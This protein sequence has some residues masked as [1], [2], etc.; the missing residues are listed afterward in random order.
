M[1][2][3]QFI[4]IVIMFVAASILIAV[5][6]FG[7]NVVDPEYSSP[8]EPVLGGNTIKPAETEAPT[9][10]SEGTD[11]PNGTSDPSDATDGPTAEPTKD[12]EAP[13][14]FPSIHNANFIG[15]DNSFTYWSSY[16]KDSGNGQ[17][18]PVFDEN[19][20]KNIGDVEY[21]FIKNDSADEWEVYLTFAMH[22]D[23]GETAKILDALKSANAKATFFVTAM[24]IQDNPELVKRM[25]D[26]GH[27]I[28]TRGPIGEDTE[29][30]S[31]EEF[32]AAMLEVEKE[33]Q[34]LFG[35]KERMTVYRPDYFSAR[36][37]KVAE[38]LEY[39]IVFRTYTAV[40]DEAGWDKNKTDSAEIAL[41]LWERGAYEGSV[42]EFT[43]SKHI[44]GA[45]AAYLKECNEN[46][47]TFKRLDQ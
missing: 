27:L 28:G 32:A 21:V 38:A 16:W 15:I 35:E 3:S 26:E 18:V 10:D 2:K 9:Q 36:T 46:N 31:A 45:I 8:T 5:G 1:K 14:E 24:Y 23:Y 25:K 44:S 20:K 39:E 30:M 47:I 34:K 17:N 22:Y 6:A 4:T 43:V 29:D 37:L 13:V 12:P 42:P 40:S 11:D 33:Y 19:I 7:K 41:R